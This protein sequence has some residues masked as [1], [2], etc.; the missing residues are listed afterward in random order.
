[1]FQIETY[2]SKLFDELN[3]GIWDTKIME[4]PGEGKLSAHTFT[5]LSHII[6]K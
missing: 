1:M 5:K 4:I 6:Y 3:G 2:L